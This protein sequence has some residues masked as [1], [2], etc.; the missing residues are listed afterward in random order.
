MGRWSERRDLIGVQD[1]GSKRLCEAREMSGEENCASEDKQL[2]G[3]IV[4][5]SSFRG[6]GTYVD[7]VIPFESNWP[8]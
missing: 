4:W 1:E 3:T 2:K 6:R 8:R 5:V 7:S